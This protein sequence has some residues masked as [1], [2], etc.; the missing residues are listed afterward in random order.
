MEPLGSGSGSG[1][2]I[3]G[4][5][6]GSIAEQAGLKRGDVILEVAGRPAQIDALR[7]LVQ[8]QPAGTW[9]PLKLR[10]GSE[11][12]ELVARFPAEP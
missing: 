8:R 9:L 12:L 1:I 3:S 6:A 10:R 11:E 5:T 4:V 2:R 7:A